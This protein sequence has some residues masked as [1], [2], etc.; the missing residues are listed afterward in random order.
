MD[1]LLISSL[2]PQ[3]L[4]LYQTAVT[5]STSSETWAE[6]Q[7]QIAEMVRCE[8]DFALLRRAQRMHAQSQ[9]LRDSVQQ[10]RKQVAELT[11][12][13]LSLQDQAWVMQ[14]LEREAARR[15]IST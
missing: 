14:A 5:A 4:S 15:S 6:Q 11:G 13:E 12:S 7:T 3:T 8:F 2:L 9:K 10:V 1:T